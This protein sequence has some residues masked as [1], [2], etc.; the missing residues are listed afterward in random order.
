MIDKPET[1]PAIFCEIYNRYGQMLYHICLN[2]LKRPMDAEDAV[3]EVFLRYFERNPSF[4]SEEHQKA[5]LIRT[6]INYCKDQF[7]GFWHKRVNLLATETRV[8]PISF[9]DSESSCLIQ[10]MLKLPEKQSVCLYLFYVQELS[11]KNISHALGIGQSAV[12]MR[13]KRGRESLRIEMEGNL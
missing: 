8:D 13:L 11:V 6:A 1:R 2:Y 7:K 4:T 12:K 3:Q 9:T 10:A 5:W